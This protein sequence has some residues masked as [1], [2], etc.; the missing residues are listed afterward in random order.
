MTTHFRLYILD[1]GV[2]EYYEWSIHRIPLPEGR[3]GVVC[4]FRDIS[5]QIS[6]REAIL[7]SEERLRDLNESLEREVLQ[8]TRAL[9][10][11]MTERH[12]AEQALQQAQRL[13]AI[14]R[15]TGGVA[16]D[17]NN[18][19]TVV[20]GQTELMLKSANGSDAVKRAASA[21]QHAADRGARL[22]A[23]LLAFS[24]SQN[25]RPSMVA[26]NQLITSVDDLLRRAAG[27]AIQLEC[28]AAPDLWPT[29]VDPAQFESA[30][31]NL[32]INARDA[33]PDGGTLSI[34]VDNATVSGIEAARLDVSPGDYVVVSVADTGVGM[35]PD[36]RERAF[37]PFFTTKDIGKGTGLGLAQIYGFTKQSGGVATIESAPGRGTV[38]SLYLPRTEGIVA[39]EPAPPPGP[40]DR[41]RGRTVLVVEDQAEVRELIEDMLNDLGYRVFT[42]SDSL[43]AR[44]VLKGD[45]PIDLLLTDMVMPRGSNGLDLL[46]EAR[47]I[48]QDMKVILMSGFARD[49]QG[50]L[51]TIA[52]EFAFLEKP[53]RPAELASL[54][55]K[56]LENRA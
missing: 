42:A 47:R 13:E 2:T 7:A 24:R 33:M 35:P 22:T 17:F 44:T 14:G 31:L 6:A 30:L 48:R 45:V 40:P 26:I 12:K 32:V 11:E 49:M 38:V 10:T 51:G 53:F 50:G 19:L 21:I 23:Q 37:E 41:G 39:R 18:M 8:R 16:H 9:A 36:V 55:G 28:T 5:V 43:A 25:L 34:N 20:A 4:Y 56:V 54:I 29:L 46:K 27:E 15:L 3:H 1:R 52:D